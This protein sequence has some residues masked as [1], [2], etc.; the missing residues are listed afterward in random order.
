MRAT[1]CR[2][3]FRCGPGLSASISVEISLL[4]QGSRLAPLGDAS[5]IS[6]VIVEFVITGGAG[7]S[8]TVSIVNL[9]G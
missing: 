3:P 4:W 9:I 5:A 1:G 2:R 8:A 6:R 7:A